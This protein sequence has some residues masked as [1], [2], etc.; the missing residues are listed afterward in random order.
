MTGRLA[1]PYLRTSWGRVRYREHFGRGA[2][3]YISARH[4]RWM[5]RPLTTVDGYGL[6]NECEAVGGWQNPEGGWF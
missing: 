2:L 4:P 1:Q 6:R 3:T 5:R